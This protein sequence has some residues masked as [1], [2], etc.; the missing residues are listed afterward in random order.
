MALAYV[1]HAHI[2]MCCIADPLQSW[3]LFDLFIVSVIGCFFTRWGDWPYA[4]PATCRVEFFCQGFLSLRRLQSIA[5]DFHQADFSFLVCSHSLC[6]SQDAHKAVVVRTNRSH[7]GFG[8]RVLLIL[9]E[10]PAK[11]YE[12]RLPV[13]RVSQPGAAWCPF[14]MCWRE[15][16][17]HRTCCR[18]A[19]YWQKRLTHLALFLHFC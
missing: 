4:Q 7:S 19:M 1:L 12:S 3:F 15:E 14:T 17:L 6:L 2:L 11:A 13:A 9:D 10:L 16:P 5:D 8:V 18:E